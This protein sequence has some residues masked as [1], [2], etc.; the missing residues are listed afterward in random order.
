M[1]YLHFANL[2]L[3]HDNLIYNAE[4][5]LLCAH[6]IVQASAAVCKERESSA[7]FF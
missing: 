7:A 4:L 1:S 5:V 2:F 6:K 3:A